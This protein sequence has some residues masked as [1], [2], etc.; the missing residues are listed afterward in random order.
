MNKSI[1]SI[2]FFFIVIWRWKDRLLF[3]T[4]WNDIYISISK[5]K[6]GNSKKKMNV[7]K[8]DHVTK[9]DDHDRKKRWS[10]YKMMI[11]ICRH[12]AQFKWHK[13]QG[14]WHNSNGTRYNSN[15]TVIFSVQR[16]ISV[17]HFNWN[18]SS[19]CRISIA[20]LRHPNVYR[21]R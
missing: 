10:C 9:N 19:W 14:K 5:G 17:E 18:H 1:W 7:K 20:M 4:K 11:V 13:E 3:Y 12:K 8:D 21:S 15:D 16:H 6:K 2:Y